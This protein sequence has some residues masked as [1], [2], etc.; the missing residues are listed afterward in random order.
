[1]FETRTQLMN[2]IEALFQ[3]LMQYEGELEGKK[4]QYIE[5]IDN[6]YRLT[7]QGFEECAKRLDRLEE[8]LYAII[9]RRIDK[10]KDEYYPKSALNHFKAI[11]KEIYEEQAAFE[12]DQDE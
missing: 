12:G 6:L 4:E 8:G 2:K 1:M 5:S 3:E 11:A 7:A 10:D 9:S